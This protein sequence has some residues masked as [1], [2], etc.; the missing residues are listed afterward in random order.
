MAAQ[1]K[2]PL[3]TSTVTRIHKDGRKLSYVLTVMQEPQRA[4]ACGSGAKSSADR[5]PV[6]PPP[7]VKL[8]I[9]Q[10]KGTPQQED[11]TFSYPANFFLFAT[12]EPARPM[13][14]G[15]V[16][17][18]PP[19]IPVLTGM[20][21]S[22]M[23]YLDRPEEA[24]Y[25]I[26]PD[27]SVRH[28]GR[29][30]LS[31]NLYEGEKEEEG[32]SSPDQKPKVSLMPGSLPDTSFDWRLEVKSSVF[33]VFSAKKFPGLSESTVLSRIVAEQ[34]CRV[35]IRR[36]VRMRR[37]EKP[38]ESFDEAAEDG[39]A[40]A[41]RTAEPGP[42]RERS[43]SAGSD[44][45]R[46]GQRRFSGE[47][48]G[49]PYLEHLTPSPGP[50]HG[51]PSQGGYLGFGGGQQF[52]APP[53]QFAPPPPPAGQPMYQSAPNG[54]QQHQHHQHQSQ[55]PQHHHPQQQHEQHQSQY[56]PP[57]PPPNNYTYER[58]HPQSA[59]PSVPARE[60]RDYQSEPFRKASLQLTSPPYSSGP[61]PVPESNYNRP[62]NHGYSET[63]SPP[64][65]NPVYLPPI[66]IPV[67]PKPEMLNSPTGPLQSIRPI[68]PS[69]QS[70]SFLRGAERPGVYSQHH[71]PSSGPHIAPAIIP[72]SEPAPMEPMRNANGK[73]PLDAAFDNST[74][75]D[76]LHNGQRPNLSHNDPDTADVEH[77]RMIYKR[78]DGSFLHRV[79][80]IINQI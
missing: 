50:G 25:F 74:V 34:G 79:S 23:A 28:E 52:Q 55:Q 2:G 37:R 22:G 5:R 60:Q 8:S 29:Y 38:T 17:Q 36:D 26:F 70:P 69:L 6:D 9:F 62:P 54:Y 40:R 11:I 75:N 18:S 64:T 27:L 33:T 58:Q 46:D 51:G 63:R 16:Q 1:P 80:A 47:F 77:P 14:T 4:R 76:P 3:P 42:Y 13:A 10:D 31:F 56:R 71:G 67:D 32:S 39:Y 66:N 59:F 20:P 78:A 45:G 21:V 48:Q 53:S 49:Q 24:G 43:N 57:P 41:G 68:A 72:A 35:R 15:R 44:E 65:S 12:L 61:H 73:R 19:Q 7:V 30:Y